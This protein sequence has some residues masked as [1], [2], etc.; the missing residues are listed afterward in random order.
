MLTLCLCLLLLL[1]PVFFLLEGYFESVFHRLYKFRRKILE[2]T[3]DMWWD[4]QRRKQNNE[5]NFSKI[6]EMTTKITTTT[7]T[8]TKKSVL[9]MKQNRHPHQNVEHSDVQFRMVHF[10][11]YFSWKIKYNVWLERS[12][13]KTRTYKHTH[14]LTHE[15]WKMKNWREPNHYKWSR[16]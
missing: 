10:Y 7:T 4:M 15:K 14:T 8:T 3:P 1:F 6:V 9:Q 11:I 16:Y 2:E 5:M 12:M 13:N